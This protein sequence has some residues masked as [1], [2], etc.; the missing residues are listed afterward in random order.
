MNR[1]QAPSVSYP[2]G[3]CALYGRLLLGAW[4]LGLAVVSVQA[5]YAGQVPIGVL[6]LLA[7]AGV[8]AG[9]GWRAAPRGQLRWVG[10][11][12]WEWQT[13]DRTVVLPAPVL[14]WR[15]RDHL[16]LQMP[17]GPRDLRWL[18][19]ERWRDPSRWDALC[20]AATQA[21]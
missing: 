17:L 19:V 10:G 18:W 1:R 20:R 11:G 16:L 13:D 3:P 8:L 21:R 12:G 15:G 9:R 7:L 5:W 2:V 4:G 6:P 14:V